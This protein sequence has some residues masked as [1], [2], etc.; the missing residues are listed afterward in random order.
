M[1]CIFLSIYIS[2]TA[3]KEIPGSQNVVGNKY[4][5][6]SQK[7]STMASASQPSAPRGRRGA[8]PDIQSQAAFPTLAA[9]KQD[10]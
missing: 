5:P 1:I 8:P 2:T 4:V 9:A 6:P 7:R 3:P 10:M